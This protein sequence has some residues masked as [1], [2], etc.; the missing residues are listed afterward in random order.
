MAEAPLTRFPYYLMQAYRLDPIPFAVPPE[1]SAIMNQ[2]AKHLTVGKRDG[3]LDYE[4]HLW[5][6]DMH[7]RIL[8][9]PNTLA[10]A[11]SMGRSAALA[12]LIVTWSKRS[13]HPVTKTFLSSNDLS[14]HEKFIS[15]LPNLAA[16]YFS[17]EVLDSSS[18]NN[19]RPNLLK[20][21]R[22]RIHAMA[23]QKLL[24]TC[25]GPTIDFTFIAK[26]RTEFY[27]AFYTRKPE[28]PDL[29]DAERHGKLICSAY[30]L[31]SLL[32]FCLDALGT[33]RRNQ[34]GQV[35][36][37]LLDAQDIPFGTLIHEVFRNT[38]EHAY[39]DDHGGLPAKGLRSLLISSRHVSR[40]TLT[41]VNLLSVSR[42]SAIRYFHELSN[43]PSAASAENLRLLEISI[44]DT[45]PG[46]GRSLLSSVT[47]TD[48]EAVANCF[49]KHQ[50]RKTGPASG[51]GLYRA[52]RA[53]QSLGAFIRVRTS[54]TEAFFASS[55]DFHPD[56]NP[57]SYVEGDLANVNGTLITI[58]I[59]MVA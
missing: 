10:E 59:P 50:T 28:L 30:S 55:P 5:S 8:R 1:P 40:K 12:Q 42:P 14:S 3:I 45:G 13:V 49:K 16:A 26:A 35:L 21:A 11:G 25:K 34:K 7:K 24:D 33:L 46:F 52:L 32:Y 6:H 39:L 47:L 29:L 9:I 15:T 48:K 54:S 44:L 53:I 17:A 18:Q 22:P 4:R 27:D 58:G 41:D 57:Y 36:R 56:M 20:A 51:I 43:R 37:R 19:I 38:A 23:D 2:N 31:N